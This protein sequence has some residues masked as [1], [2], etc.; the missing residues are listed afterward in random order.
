ME[1]AYRGSYIFNTVT[2]STELS[3]RV[4]EM[5]FPGLCWANGNYKIVAILKRI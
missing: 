2:G 4:R 3:I 5:S 1:K